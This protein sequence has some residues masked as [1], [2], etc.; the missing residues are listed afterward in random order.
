MERI[1]LTEG[2]F[3]ASYRQS[4]GGWEVTCFSALVQHHLV[5]RYMSANA[6]HG[7]GTNRWWCY[8]SA[9]WEAC[10]SKPFQFSGAAQFCSSA[11]LSLEQNDVSAQCPGA[12]PRSFCGTCFMHRCVTAV[13]VH[14]SANSPGNWFYGTFS[15]CSF[16]TPTFL[17]LHVWCSPIPSP[18]T[19]LTI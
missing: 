1:V 13:S 10:E 14:P 12:T 4:K 2:I 9:T 3:S 17:G 19:R 15:W 8:G 5:V 6:V 11:C 18:S 16:R 7:K